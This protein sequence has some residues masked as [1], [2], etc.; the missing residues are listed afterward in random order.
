MSSDPWECMT[1]SVIRATSKGELTPLPKESRVMGGEA[2]WT[3]ERMG[4]LGG[5]A[6]TG[7]EGVAC[8]L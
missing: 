3:V 5:A 2:E 8:L 4:L 6:N 7:V 1:L